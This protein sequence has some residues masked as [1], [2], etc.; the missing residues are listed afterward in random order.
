MYGNNMNNGMGQYPNNGMGQ[1]PNNG[2]P[3]QNMYQ[4]PKKSNTGLIVGIILLLI[5]AAVVV[6]F[7]VKPFDKE[8]NTPT[9]NPPVNNND[10]NNPPVNNDDDNNTNPPVNTDDNNTNPP[11]NND[12]NNTN[13]PVNNDDNNN[14]VGGDRYSCTNTTVENDIN[15]TV[16]LDISSEGSNTCKMTMEYIYAR[17]NGQAFT[18]AEKTQV[19]NSVESTL[20]NS[21]ALGTVSNIKT[22]LRDGKIVVTADSRISSCTPAELKDGFATNDYTCH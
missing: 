19:G 16:N 14:T 21:S 17:T 13:P 11:V 15:M 18:E 2:M 8:E 22:E 12:D 5:I 10:N 9:D 7:V 20:K 3:P 6:I 4:P 1:Y